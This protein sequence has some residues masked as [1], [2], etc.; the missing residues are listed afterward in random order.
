MRSNP[1][2]LLV[3]AAL[4]LVSSTSVAQSGDI[5]ATYLEAMS[6]W[7]ACVVSE[8]NKVALTSKQSPDDIVTAYIEDCEYEQLKTRAYEAFAKGG[9]SG[10]YLDRAVTNSLAKFAD[11][12]RVEAR[13]SIVTTRVKAGQ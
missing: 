3:G 5:F 9:L 7:R 4:T 8:T 10:L 13:K 12:T 2:S 1:A 6:Q 11:G